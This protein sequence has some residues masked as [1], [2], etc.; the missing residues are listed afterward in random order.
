MP[1]A[2]STARV[3]E[4]GGITVTAEPRVEEQEKTERQVRE[5][6]IKARQRFLDQTKFAIE[7]LSAGSASLCRVKLKPS[8]GTKKGEPFVADT[9]E[10]ER[11]VDLARQAAIVAEDALI[12]L[13]RSARLEWFE[14]GLASGE[15]T[16]NEYGFVYRASPGE[17]ID[18]IDRE[19]EHK[20]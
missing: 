5:R 8:R 15:L 20:P 4:G 12:R 7:T 2:G 6:H 14:Y 17:E 10:A 3:S 9:W 18:H 11:L 1:I 19:Y 13:R 16:R